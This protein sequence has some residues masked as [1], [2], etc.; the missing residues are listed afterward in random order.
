MKIKA[1]ANAIKITPASTQFLCGYPHVERYST[2]I[3]T[4]L[5]SSAL[6]LDDGQKRV[7]IISNDIL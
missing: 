5:I 4:D 7:L 6:Y 3:D 1:G 2:G